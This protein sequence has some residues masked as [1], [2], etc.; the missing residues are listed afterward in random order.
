MTCP[1]SQ[2]RPPV[3]VALGPRGSTPAPNGCAAHAHAH[4]SRANGTQ[5]TCVQPRH[6]ELGGPVTSQNRTGS[7]A[8]LGR[9]LMVSAAGRGRKGQSRPPTREL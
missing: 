1:R 6:I 2:S 7:L 5:T 4:A 9:L 3:Q 8:G